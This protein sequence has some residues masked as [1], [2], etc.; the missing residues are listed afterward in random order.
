MLV[1]S[2]CAMV[3]SRFYSMTIL[4]SVNSYFEVVR[5]WYAHTTKTIFTHCHLQE[6]DYDIT[7]DESHRSPALYYRRGGARGIIVVSSRIQTSH[8]ASGSIKNIVHPIALVQVAEMIQSSP[9][10]NQRVSS[11]LSNR[12]TM[13]CVEKALG[14]QSE[15]R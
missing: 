14:W 10:A 1:R 3:E 8:L 12:A 9:T 6:K 13:L 7:G 4:Y 5:T 11:R 15:R 2:D